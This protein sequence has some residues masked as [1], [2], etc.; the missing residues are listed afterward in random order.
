MPGCLPVPHARAQLRDQRRAELKESMEAHDAVV[1]ELRA[2][3]A[4]LQA[5]HDAAEVK[6]G[7]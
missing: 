4:R 7:S 6:V 3:I 2:Q 5:M 1:A